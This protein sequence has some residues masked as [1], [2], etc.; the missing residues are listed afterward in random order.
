M[1]KKPQMLLMVWIGCFCFAAPMLADEVAVI[2]LIPLAEL[3]IYTPSSP[4]VMTAWRNHAADSENRPRRAGRIGDV[5][6]TEEGY[7]SLA[8][9][10]VISDWVAS[11]N[12]HSAPE[13]LDLVAV[14]ENRGTVPAGPVDV[15]LYRNRKVGATAEAACKAPLSVPHPRTQATWEGSL[16]L[17]THTI[18]SLEARTVLGLKLGSFPIHDGLLD[19]L[20]A[21]DMWPWEVKYVVRLRCTVCSLDTVSVSIP[22]G[23]VC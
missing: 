5:M 22:I 19:D 23:Q 7:Q 17:G 4:D 2:R 14:V 1:T 3:P 12:D 8:E 10:R 20:R 15:V 9:Y 6:L 18:D 13:Y 21:M 11:H 16:M